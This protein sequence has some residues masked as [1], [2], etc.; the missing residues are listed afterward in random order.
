MAKGGGSLPR[1][2]RLRSEVPDVPEPSGLSDLDVRAQRALRRL[3]E[4]AGGRF[5]SAK[6]IPIRHLDLFA[7]LF[8]E[9]AVR[10]GERSGDGVYFSGQPGLWHA[11]DDLYALQDPNRWD[12]LR[13]AIIRHLEA[14]GWHRRTPPRGSAF[15]VPL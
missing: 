3:V 9:W 1:G 7:A 6:A 11:L 5:D 8:Q 4:E 13:N 2:R 10:Y 15:D 12:R 14:Q